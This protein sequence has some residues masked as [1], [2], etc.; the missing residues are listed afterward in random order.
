MVPPSTKPIEPEE[1]I[2]QIERIPIIDVRSPGEFA[3]GHIPG[4]I[5]LPLF[6]DEER[7]SIG[8]S[9]KQNGRRLAVLKGLDIA[10]PKMRQLAEQAHKIAKSRSNDQKS[11]RLNV[12]CWRGGMRSAAMSWLFNQIDIETKTLRGG[13]K[14]YRKWVHCVFDKTWNL[15]VISGLTGSGKTFQLN[16]LGVRGEQ[17]LDLEALASHRGSAFGNLGMSPQP[18]VEQFENDLAKT[19]MALNSERV[20]WVE[21]EGRKIGTVVVPP[22]FFQQLRH[23]PAVFM[24]VPRS[25]RA[26]R[27]ANDYGSSMPTQLETCIRNIAKRL[28]GQNVKRALE[29]LQNHQYIACANVLLE[30]YDRAYLNSKS[31]IPRCTTIDLKTE[32]PES[33][34]TTDAILD[35]FKQSI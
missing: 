22:S 17:V 15:R 35:I 13:Y 5:N 6:D 9:Y 7:S 18:T 24:D 33:R 14:A 31:K 30:Y 23:A 26:S 32:N 10:G 20:I 1:L 8:K 27:L 4:A 21:D 28:G 29:L 25:T 3:Q 19:L 12:H 2:E 11:L 34:Q 16:E